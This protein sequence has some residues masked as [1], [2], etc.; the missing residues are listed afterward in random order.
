MKQVMKH[1][2]SLLI[3]VAIPLL[4]GAVGGL[5]T[6][7]SL[8]DWYPSLV[9]PSWNPPNWVFGPVWT[10]LYVL[11]GVAAWR[12][13]RKGPNDPGVRSGLI[14]FGVQLFFN[15]LWSLVFFGL[16]MPGG[17]LVEIA[18]TWILILATLVSFYRID[19]TA[20]LLLVPYQLWATFATVLNAA[21]WWL[22]R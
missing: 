6:S 22:N 14:L 7:S 19:R 1:S 20:G 13:W 3:A 5:A 2:V 21:I 12:V 18:I 10:I 15:L 11:M 16:R 17:A 9:K 4:V 8:S